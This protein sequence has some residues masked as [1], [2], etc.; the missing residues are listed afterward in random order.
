MNLILVQSLQFGG[1]ASQEN[2]ACLSSLRC[3]LRT[4]QK[5]DRRPCVLRPLLAAVIARVAI[6]V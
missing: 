1:D 3:D 5:I 2:V 6:A 4:R